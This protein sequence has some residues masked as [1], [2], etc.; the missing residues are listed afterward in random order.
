MLKTLLV[1]P[2]VFLTPHDK[3]TQWFLWGSD[4]LLD[5]TPKLFSKQKPFI[6][7][8]SVWGVL[9][10]TYVK[11]HKWLGRLQTQV[12]TLLGTGQDEQLPVSLRKHLC[13]S[14][15][16]EMILNLSLPVCFILPRG[17]WKTSVKQHIFMTC[18]QCRP[19][20][21]T[22]LRCRSSEVL[23]T[24]GGVQKGWGVTQGVLVTVLLLWRDKMAKATLVKES[25]LRVSEV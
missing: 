17:N 20:S 21:C 2:L 23:Q 24:K 15:N 14:W 9:F 22:A 12:S 5:F 1:C 11:K 13:E 3:G 4:N 8:F 25:L 10:I 16:G 18:S 7:V 19:L 6:F